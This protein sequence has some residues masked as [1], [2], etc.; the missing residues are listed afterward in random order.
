MKN[1]PL[2]FTVLSVLCLIEPLI[3][4]LYF[5]ASTHF[6]FLVIMA[7]LKARNTFMEVFDF[8]LVFPLAG[9]LIVKLR[10]W[11]YFAFMGILA[12]INYNIFTY[13]KYTWPY[14]SDTPFMYNYVIAFLSLAVFSYFLMPKVRE[15]FFD[16]RVRWW[17]PM[18]R[19]NVQI[20]CKLHSKNLA[21]PTEIINISKTGAFLMES[22]YINVGDRLEMV[23]NYMGV[24]IEVPVEV[25][26]KHAIKGQM[27]FGVKFHF[28]NFSQSLRMAKLISVLRRTNAE[29]KPAP[30]LAA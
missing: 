11:S 14:N 9:L 23:F 17:E 30:K 24:R 7:N 4:I 3:K 21:F 16:R 2:I 18:A 27:G 28:K 19:Y 1:K 20:N 15:P 13:E 12:Y 22:R 8:W 5:K 26:N 10:K 25:V 6:D 29:Y